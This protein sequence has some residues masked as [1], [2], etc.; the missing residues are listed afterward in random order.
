VEEREADRLLQLGVALELDVG[1][2]PEL[3]EVRP[4]VVEEAL[5]AGV[6]PLC[7]R[8]HDL[9][10]HGGERALTRPA[11]GEELDHPQS[12]PRGEFARDGNAPDIGTA[13]RNRFRAVRA[14]D[15]M[16]HAGGHQEAAAP[17]RVSEE[18][19][20]VAPEEVLRLERGLQRCGGAWVFLFWAAGLVRD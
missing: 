3:A 14:F 16:V 18:Y 13:L 8:R 2:V 12:F 20:R 6:A 15:D 4:L 17:G 10:A 7:E 19:A 1:A 5:P 9:V 11:V